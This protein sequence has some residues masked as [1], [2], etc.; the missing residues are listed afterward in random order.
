MKKIRVA[1]VDDSSFMRKAVVR[2]LAQ[3]PRIVV[4]GTAASGEEL[5]TQLDTWQP[6]VVTL[7]LFMPGMGGL[8]TIDRI[9]EK[10]PLPVILLSSHSRE[11][12]PLTIEALH[13]GA[14]DF[15]DKQRYS[16]V[17]FQALGRVLIDKILLVTGAHVHPPEPA[18]PPPKR[19]HMGPE[20]RA[21]P[22]V[23]SPRPTR[24][25]S[26]DLLLIGASTGGPVA[27]RE[28]L[29]DL[30]S[31][32]RVPAVVVQHMPK[33]FTRAFAERLNSQ[34]PVPVLE[35]LG[36]EPLLPSTVYIAPAEHHLVIRGRPGELSV[37]A[38]REPEDVTHRPS[39]D[40]LFSSAARI[41]ELR[42]VALLLTGMGSDGAEGMKELAGTGAQ[43]L[44]QDA[45]TSVVYGMPR[46]A[47]EL[48]AA[49]EIL[50]LGQIADRLR[51]LIG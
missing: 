40:V 2:M 21:H 8:R 19:K 27:I 9:M 50:P 26:C 42:V 30:G 20:R 18:P 10:R 17:D 28:I 49:H 47:A 12:A 4:V 38:T 13:R 37:V 39:V 43:T 24:A 16:L 34:L 41:P 48:E 36:N 15:I 32:L 44:A 22:R 1:V 5:L 23:S 46:A 35:V 7:D 31:E 6:D 25:P 3:E 29:E 33:G 11:R 14:V 51:D 45:D